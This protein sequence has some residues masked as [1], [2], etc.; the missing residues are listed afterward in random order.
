MTKEPLSDEQVLNSVTGI[1]SAYLHMNRLP[2]SDV[3]DFVQ[4]VHSAVAGLG[5]TQ[6]KDTPAVPIGKSVSPGKITCLECG[7]KFQA[8]KRHL[9]TSHA[10]TPDQYRAKWELPTTYPMVASQYSKRRSGIAKDLGLGKR[11]EGGN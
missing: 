7:L 1:V 2:K 8:I 3:P 6:P 9:R 11:P 5:K 4:E 10:Y